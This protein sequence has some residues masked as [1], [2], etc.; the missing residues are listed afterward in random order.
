MLRL[1][2]LVDDEC[3][4]GDSDDRV[5]WLVDGKGC[6]ST[7]GLN[8]VDDHVFGECIQSI[9]Q[10]A[11]PLWGFGKFSHKY[12]SFRCLKSSYPGSSRLNLHSQGVGFFDKN[13]LF[14]I[15]KNSKKSENPKVGTKK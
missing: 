9:G 7:A 8:L 6:G 1:A 13:Y 14:F 2:D 3:G 4:V 12:L 11:L 10:E 15:V 5:L